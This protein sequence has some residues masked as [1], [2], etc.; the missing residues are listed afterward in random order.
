MVGRIPPAKNEPV[1]SYAP[2][3]PERKTLQ[4]ALSKMSE[5][6]RD[7][8]AFVGD[9]EVRGETVDVVMPHDHH[10]VVGKAH[11]V[12]KSDVE[13]AIA[14]A[15]AA[16]PEWAALPYESRASIL[17]KAADLLTG[18]Y[19]DRI[20]A[21]TM[22]GQSKTPHQAEIEA[23][24]ELADFWRF[25]VEYGDQMRREQPLSPDGQWN[26]TELRPLD[27][28]VFAVSPFNFTAI[29]GNLP[30]APAL[31]GNTV[32]WKPSPEQMLSASYVMEI[33]LEA[34]MPRGVINMVAGDPKMIGD[35]CLSS[36]KLAGLHFTGSTATFQHLW[37]TIGN[38]IDRYVSYPRIVGETGGKD[39]I[40]A[41]PSAD[42]DALACAIV[43]GGF[44]YQ[45][46]KCSAASR[47]YMPKSIWGAVKERAVAMIETLRVGDIA[48]FSNFMGAV[49]SQ[50]AF[51]RISGYVDLANLE[52]T[53]HAGGS[54]D[55][56]KG[57]F[58]Q[59]TLVEVSDPK[60]RL[61]REEI[62]GPVVT[63]WVYDDA[64]LDEALTLCDEGTA[65]GL[66]GGVFAQDRYAVEKVLN[67]LRGA[68]G[69]F[70][71]N[72]KPTGAVVG[73]QPFGGG[74]ASGTNDK[75]GSAANL[76]RWTS[77]RAIKEVFVPATDY[78]YPYMGEE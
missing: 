6:V 50:K 48:D 40:F 28:F 16:R 7:I 10:H 44:E 14:S 60:H 9:R 47:I 11:Q 1:K 73:Q 68:A 70:Y 45:G 59:P 26:R 13:N 2:G 61:M 24:A 77:V 5:E 71:I 36:P 20:N 22:L 43:R 57:W 3:T 67:R 21:A 54:Y 74:R 75:A 63:T 46:Q 12:N 52:G 31:M 34:G 8:P 53:V 33:L 58:V 32:V 41:H 51:D 69:N 35:T 18:P 62:F 42:V 38:N 25:N 29:A 65:Y 56:S 39:F 4:A 27:G 78:R 15:E 66:T 30:T 37:R 17:L 76:M 19:R 55:G 72:D 64:Q 23:A 49:I